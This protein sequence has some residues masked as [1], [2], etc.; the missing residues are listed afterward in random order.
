MYHLATVFPFVKRIR[1]PL[2]R[3]QAMLLM[4]ATNEIFLGIDTYLAHSIS[5]TIRPY[6][7]IPIIFGPIAG[8]LLLLAGLIALRRRPLATVIATATLL[9]STAV[10]LLGAYFHWARA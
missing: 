9:A 2:S 7:W 10:G 3:D 8:A 4:V 6:E 1:I 5:G